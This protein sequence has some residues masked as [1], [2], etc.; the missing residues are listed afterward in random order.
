MPNLKSHLDTGG[1]A[2]YVLVCD[3]QNAYHPIP[4]GESEQDKTGF[5]TQ[6]G[7]WV[8][9]RLPFGIANAPFLFSRIISLAFSHSDQKSGLLIYIDDC[10]CCSST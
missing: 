7:K 10:I 5:V 1:G 3:V 9:Q 4:V 2:R 6:N 8:F